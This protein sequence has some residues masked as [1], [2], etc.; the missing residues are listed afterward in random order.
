MTGGS[1]EGFDAKITFDMPEGLLCFMFVSCK[2]TVF[3]P[4]LNLNML[5]SQLSKK[6]FAKL[7]KMSQKMYQKFQM[8]GICRN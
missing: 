2:S 4:R 6:S 7:L 5:T 8:T 3:A 1:Q